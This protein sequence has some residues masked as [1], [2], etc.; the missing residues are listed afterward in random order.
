MELT[1]QSFVPLWQLIYLMLR[2]NCE[3]KEFAAFYDDIRRHGG[4][5]GN[6]IIRLLEVYLEYDRW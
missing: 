3:K 2:C 6:D 5:T 1:G 4:S